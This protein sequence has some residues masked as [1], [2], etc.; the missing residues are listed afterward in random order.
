M[1]VFQLFKSYKISGTTVK[2]YFEGK[3]YLWCMKHAPENEKDERSEFQELLATIGKEHEVEVVKKRYPGLKAIEIT[4]IKQ[5]L[6]E[7]KKGPKALYQF[8]IYSEKEKYFGFPD[9]LVKKKGKSKLGN[10]HYIV[11]EIKSAKNIRTEHIMQTVFYNYVLGNLQG[12]TPDAFILVNR[13]NEDFNF[14]YKKFESKL[15][16]SLI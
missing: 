6:K 8:P 15:I 10:F 7:M 2:N 9:L 16:D 5:V 14:E 4:S 13:E 12:Y 1:N 3:F 11:K